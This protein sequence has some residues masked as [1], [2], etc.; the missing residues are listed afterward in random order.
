LFFILS[1]AGVASLLAAL[2]CFCVMCCMRRPKP[3][4]S[5]CTAA[6]PDRLSGILGTVHLQACILG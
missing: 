2:L 5:V 1:C 3:Q 4:V 6:S